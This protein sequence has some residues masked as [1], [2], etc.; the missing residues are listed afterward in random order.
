MAELD[1]VPEEDMKRVLNPKTY[2]WLKLLLSGEDDE[3]VKERD[4]AKT[5]GAS[6]NYLGR[7]ALTTVESVH[8][9]LKKLCDEL[10]ER[11]A[12]DREKVR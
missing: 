12:D 9:S 6:K 1:A 3:H 10:A 8:V 7:A 11:Y 2:A 5:I 4:L